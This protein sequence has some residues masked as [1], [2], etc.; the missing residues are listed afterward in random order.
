MELNSRIQELIFGW[1]MHNFIHD[2]NI[3]DKLEDVFQAI[4]D[5]NI[6][7]LPLKQEF[8]DNSDELSDGELCQEIA[9]YLREQSSHLIVL[10]TPIPKNISKDEKGNIKSWCSNG[11]G[12]IRITVIFIASIETMREKILEFEDEMFEE[13][14]LREQDNA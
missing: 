11:W 7:D 4:M 12:M 13:I 2:E 1:D 6:K 9:G 8:L 14:Y 10:H 5:N 3:D